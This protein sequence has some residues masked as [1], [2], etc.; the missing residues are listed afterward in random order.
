MFGWFGEAAKVAQEQFGPEALLSKYEWFKDASAGL[1]KKQADL[2]VYQ[3][4]LKSL[5]GSLQGGATLEMG[6]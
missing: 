6:A 2:G 3:A 1:D 5:Q 4:R